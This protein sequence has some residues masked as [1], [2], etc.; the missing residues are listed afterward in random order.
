MRKKVAAGLAVEV[1]TGTTMGSEW[2]DFRVP[3]DRW[4]LNG[5]IKA[6]RTSTMTDEQRAAA[7]ERLR[8]ARRSPSTESSTA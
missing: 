8:A 5:A 3:A 6:K 4:S 1:E 2:A 7:A